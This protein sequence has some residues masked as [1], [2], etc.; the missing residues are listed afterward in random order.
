MWGAINQLWDSRELVEALTSRLDGIRLPEDRVPR[1]SQCGR[2]LVPWVR[3]DTFLEGSIWQKSLARYQNFLRHWLL[4][5]N[6]KRVLLLE[7]G[8]GE[9][10][11][12][13]IKLPLWEMTAELLQ[14]VRTIQ[15]SPLVGNIEF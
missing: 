7:L 1:C 13:I 14:I 5:K 4:E 8:V 6:G 9:M 10:T 3:D 15:K 11:P 2:I 12:S